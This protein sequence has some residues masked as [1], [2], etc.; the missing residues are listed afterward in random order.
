MRVHLALAGSLLCALA[1]SAVADE[2]YEWVDERGV[3]HYTD[4]RELV[5]EPFRASVRVTE[6]SGDGSYQRVI[7]RRG[8]SAPAAPAEDV[9][10]GITESQWRAEAERLDARVAEL[11]P[12]A[13]R[14]ENDHVNRS[15]GDGSRKRKAEL[16]E[17]AACAKTQSDLT[18]A[19]AE[20]DAFR[21][22]AHRAGVPP[23]WVREP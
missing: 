23:G 8:S 7:E 11:A 10:D 16:A 17:A 13:K 12:E 18:S 2:I 14:C 22:N 9:I 1:V 21:E 3:V 5:P 15:P 4:D 20:R 19:R 6:A